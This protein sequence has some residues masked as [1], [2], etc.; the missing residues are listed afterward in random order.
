[1]KDV[2]A[3]NI[4]RNQTKQVKSAKSENKETT[5]EATKEEKQHLAPAA[6]PESRYCPPYHVSD[7]ME[8]AEDSSPWLN[9]MHW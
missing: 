2:T 3:F 1:V 4:N 5:T 9:K 6:L 7:T 8:K